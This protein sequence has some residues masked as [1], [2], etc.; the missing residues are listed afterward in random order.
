M[1]SAA[2]T[3]VPPPLPYLSSKSMREWTAKWVPDWMDCDVMFVFLEDGAK[4][5]KPDLPSDS[6]YA[7]YGEQVLSKLVSSSGKRRLLVGLTMSATI[8]AH[9]ESVVVDLAGKMGYTV[10]SDDDD[11]SGRRI[12]T[13]DGHADAP[14]V[15]HLWLHRYAD[16]AGLASGTHDDDTPVVGWK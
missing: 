3:T 6:M 11:D 15:F 14:G 16:D 10:R 8:A 7:D 2:A 13:L 12:F 9:F 1:A 4:L 5:D